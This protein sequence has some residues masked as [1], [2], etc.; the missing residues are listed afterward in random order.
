MT[1]YDKGIPG[2]FT[3]TAGNVAGAGW[4]GKSIMWSRPQKTL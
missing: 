1:T 3:G 4:R 2:S